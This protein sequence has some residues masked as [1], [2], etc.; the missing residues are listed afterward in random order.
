MKEGAYARSVP[1]PSEAGSTAEGMMWGFTARLSCPAKR[2]TSP[3]ES[4]QNGSRS[5]AT[6]GFTGEVYLALGVVT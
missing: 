2:G 3:V 1:A 4:L 6:W 5:V